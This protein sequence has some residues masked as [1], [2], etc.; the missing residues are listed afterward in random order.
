M[1]ETNVKCLIR[2]RKKCP[3][4]ENSVRWCLVLRETISSISF[5]FSTVKFLT[6]PISLRKHIIKWSIRIKWDIYEWF[7][8]TVLYSYYIEQFVDEKKSPF[9]YGIQI[10]YSN[11]ATT[12]HKE[13][14]PNLDPEQIMAIDCTYVYWT[15]SKER[16]F[17]FLLSYRMQQQSDAAV[18]LSKKMAVYWPPTIWL[19]PRSYTLYESKRTTTSLYCYCSWEDWGL[20]YH[21]WRK[22]ADEELLRLQLFFGSSRQS[23]FLV[24]EECF[25]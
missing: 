5:D 21:L 10:C 19:S 17:F 24:F 18:S 14:C 4:L 11:M 2:C 16:L 25:Y 15:R 23:P 13:D 12:M 1:G 22:L 7:S 6:F 3:F 20:L 9:A 8:H